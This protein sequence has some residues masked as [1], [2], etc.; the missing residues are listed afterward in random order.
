LFQYAIFAA[1][2]LLD[3]L[4]TG[5]GIFAKITVNKTLKQIT[6]YRDKESSY[7]PDSAKIHA[8]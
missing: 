3:L 7:K 1:G 6:V 5:I 4:Y 2:I 8:K